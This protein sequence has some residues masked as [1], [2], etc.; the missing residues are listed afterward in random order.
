MRGFESASRTCA[1]RKHG[2]RGVA[3]HVGGR[4]AG[5][6]VTR[7]QGAQR[8]R[9]NRAPHS[10]GPKGMPDACWAAAT[11]GGLSEGEP[12]RACRMRAAAAGARSCSTGNVSH[13]EAQWAACL[14]A[15]AEQRPRPPKR[16]GSCAVRRGSSGSGLSAKPRRV[17]THVAIAVSC[18]AA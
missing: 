2:L 7:R 15:V 17:V 12:C 6:P 14:S 5:P 13:Q 4:T 11:D 3:I 1:R 16:A 8:Q 9:A 10:L 18:C